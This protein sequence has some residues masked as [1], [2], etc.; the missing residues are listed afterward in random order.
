MNILSDDRFTMEA[1]TSVARRL[2]EAPT[3]LGRLG[4]F[5]DEPLDVTNVAVEYADGL[6]GLVDPSPRGGPGQ[7]VK[8]DSTKIAS[9]AI[10][11]FQRD[12]T[13]LA[14]EVQS[15]RA[16]G[17]VDQLET[18]QERVARKIARHKNDLDF[19]REHQRV[20]AI[21][22]Q[23]TDSKGRV[24]ENLFD[25]FGIAPPPPIS[26]ALGTAGTDVRGKCTKVLDALSDALDV[27]VGG[28]L[29][30]VTAVV[31]ADFWDALISHDAVKSTYQ[32]WEAAAALRG[33]ARRPF[34]FGGIRWVRYR[35]SAKV[36]AAKN[37]QP[38]IPA[39]NARFVVG[40]LPDL[41]K[42]Y[43]APADYNETVNTQAETIY[44]KMTEMPNGKGYDL[45]VQRNC[46]SICTRPA[47]LISATA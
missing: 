36:K 17:T 9:F 39:N 3:V 46:L 42:T 40:G 7:T 35:S 37:N 1:L 19:T 10:P 28:D 44:A 2:P 14:D 34:T 26:F 18:V 29:Y 12:D 22:G 41:Y 5:E 20:G 16:F 47:A 45:E 31:G 23:L 11:H 43:Y 8:H 33:D 32:N 21:T 6:I 30:P 4:I 25:R 13:V 27:E 38:L 15:R 24:Y